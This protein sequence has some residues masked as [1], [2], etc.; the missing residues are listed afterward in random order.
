[1][2]KRFPP[3]KSVLL[4]SADG[5]RLDNGI[6]PLDS[7]GEGLSGNFGKAELLLIRPGLHG[8]AVLEGDSGIVE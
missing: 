1:M 5:L 3:P 7:I 4:L 6:G 8:L 2:A